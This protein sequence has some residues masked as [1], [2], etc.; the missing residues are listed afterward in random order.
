MEIFTREASMIVYWITKRSLNYGGDRYRL[1][2]VAL[3]DAGRVSIG[4]SLI[5]Y[6]KF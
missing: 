4:N 3:R 6:T 1:A 2:V 5:T